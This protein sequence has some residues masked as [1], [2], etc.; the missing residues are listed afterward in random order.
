MACSIF[1]SAIFHDGGSVL[2][3]MSRL[4]HFRTRGGAMII[5]CPQCETRYTADAASFSASG[6]KVRCSKCGHLWHQAAPEPER[7]LAPEAPAAGHAA[8]LRSATAPVGRSGG[9][10]CQRLIA[11]TRGAPCA[12]DAYRR[13]P[14]RTLSLDFQP[15]AQN[16]W[17]WAEPALLGETDRA[18]AGGEASPAAFRESG[19]NGG[20]KPAVL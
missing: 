13:R 7:V 16:P 15:A 3:A 10:A 19:L 9:Q 18:A 20:N 6:R 1:P 14:A 2:A 17:R 11:R 12:V 8:K 5:T 4:R